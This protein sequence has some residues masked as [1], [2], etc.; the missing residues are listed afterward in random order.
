MKRYIGKIALVTGGA[1]GIGKATTKRLCEEGATVVIADFNLKSAQ[2][3]ASQLNS[4]GHSALAIYFNALET[5]SCR[6]IVE[7]TVEIYGKIDVLVNVVGGNNLHKDLAAGELDIDYFD[8]LMHLNVRSMIVS[9]QSALRYMKKEKRGAIVNI[10]SIGGL[11]GDYRGT[12]YGIAKAGVIN[13]TRYIASQYGKFGIRCNSVAPG[14]VLTPAAKQNLT[15]QEDKIYL[16]HL[17]LPYLGEPEQ[18]AA[19]V[20]FL[21][22][23]DAAYITGQTLV[24][25]GGMTCHNPTI[26][27]MAALS[28]PEKL[29]M[30]FSDSG[31]EWR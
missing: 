24:A 13:L 11:T 14:L 19:T 7:K 30:T 9:I 17:P 15:D 3:Y 27:D 6:E 5:E 1:N 25:D 26:A 10:S 4:Q 8:E 23:S 20:A 12:L 29:T 28:N 18:I 16:K 2:E 31:T 21:A 22:S